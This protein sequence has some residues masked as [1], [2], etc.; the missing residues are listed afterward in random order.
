M[1]ILTPNSELSEWSRR[2]VKKEGK[3][4]DGAKAGKGLSKRAEKGLGGY[5]KKEGG[6]KKMRGG[7]EKDERKGRK[8][9]Q[10]GERSERI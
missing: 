3:G 4:L 6:S 9:R 2:T 8:R 10:L 7:V 1:R 5:D